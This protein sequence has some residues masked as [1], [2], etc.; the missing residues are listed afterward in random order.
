MFVIEANEA[1]AAKKM[2]IL[3]AVVILLTGSAIGP[4]SFSHC[5]FTSSHLCRC[6]AAFASSAFLVHEHI[7]KG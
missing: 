1:N 7:A 2:A 5:T 6:R 3:M 4:T